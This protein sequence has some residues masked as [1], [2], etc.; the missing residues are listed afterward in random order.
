MHDSV[1]LLMND[2][3]NT[4]RGVF[5]DPTL[6]YNNYKMIQQILPTERL[7]VKEIILNTNII[8]KHFSEDEIKKLTGI[9]F[10]SD[11]ELNEI[12]EIHEIPKEIKNEVGKI[13]IKLNIFKENMKTFNKLLGDNIFSLEETDMEKIPLLFRDKF[14]IYRDIKIKEIPE[15]EMFSYFMDRFQFTDITDE[16]E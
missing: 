5:K 10:V 2:A 1:Y 3:N 16:L 11:G 13:K 4:I 9:N 14:E 15:Q 7:I 6:L 12:H 8:R